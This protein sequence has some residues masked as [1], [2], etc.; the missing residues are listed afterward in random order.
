MKQHPT[1]ATQRETYNAQNPN[2]MGQRQTYNVQKQKFNDQLPNDKLPTDQ[3]PNIV[4]SIVSIDDLH[5][6]ELLGTVLA[7]HG[8]GARGD[9]PQCR[10]ANSAAFNIWSASAADDVSAA[11]YPSSAAFM[12]FL[13]LE[14]PRK[15]WCCITRYTWADVRL[16]TS[17][18]FNISMRWPIDHIQ[19]HGACKHVSS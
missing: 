6:V 12:A 18:H 15:N 11:A 13:F 8:G 16:R 3:R 9:P 4:V 7:L 2:A 17:M 10:R 1:H 5:Y 19:D 14:E